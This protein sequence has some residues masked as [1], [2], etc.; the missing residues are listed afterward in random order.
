MNRL[1]ERH[2]LYRAVRC[3]CLLCIR[4][5]SECNAWQ[6]HRCWPQHLD[7][8]SYILYFLIVFAY[9]SFAVYLNSSHNEP[10]SP[11]RPVN[12][13]PSRHFPAP[14]RR[15]Q[16]STGSVFDAPTSDTNPFSHANQAN[17]HPQPPVHPDIRTG[18]VSSPTVVP[19]K[20]PQVLP[21]PTTPPAHPHHASNPFVARAAAA[22][23]K[24]NPS[25]ERKLPPLPPRKTPP[26]LPPRSTSL[27]VS[28]PLGAP[29]SKPPP[30]PPPAK[31]P[32]RTTALMQQ[33]LQASKA[34]QEAKRIEAEREQE[35]VL[36]VL[37]SSTRSLSPPKRSGVGSTSSRSSV[38]GTGPSKPLL[39]PRPRVSPPA[40]V[41]SARSFEQ[42]A[43]AT[44]I[45]RATLRRSPSPLRSRS[46]S[47]PRSPSPSRPTTDLPPPVHPNR[48]TTQ[49]YGSS[50]AAGAGASSPS[51]SPRFGRS[52]SVHHPSP[53]PVPQ[54]RRPDSVQLLPSPNNGP[55]TPS[56]PHSSLSPKASTAPPTSSPT[57]SRLSRHLSLSA[58]E[59]LWDEMRGSLSAVRYKA[60]AGLSRR[61]WV[62]G[63]EREERL[64]AEKRENEGLRSTSNSDDG[65]GVDA[66]S[67]ADE[68]RR[69][70]A[71][72][73]DEMKWPAGDGWNQLA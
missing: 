48:K 17:D 72:E 34:A 54:R 66:E 35:R 36:Q 24:S 31:V 39:P 44:L 59:P 38:D 62:P 32:H 61:G 11:S 18:T 47:R 67:P 41:M 57:F 29:P 19:I 43:G 68:E 40:S 10:T 37:K 14:P 69:R 52:K 50:A 58:R 65:L 4:V 22:A 15:R 42:V 33:S 70:G 64:I 51:S 60:E 1:A 45:A 2:R 13:R 25:P 30:R 56:T 46:V 9:N 63:L 20:P 5:R 3:W 23:A 53:P 71:L 55:S 7:P 16:I 49:E 28:T 8:S 21:A 6:A 73:R 12:D 26:L 27:I